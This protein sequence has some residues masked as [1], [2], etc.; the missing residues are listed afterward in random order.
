METDF[1]L[2]EHKSRLIVAG[3]A[4]DG[5]DVDSVPGRA[6]RSI[7]AAVWQSSG[8]KAAGRQL[9]LECPDWRWDGLANVGKRREE[10][11]SQGPNQWLIAGGGR[12]QNT[13]RKENRKKKK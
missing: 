10:R 2:F 7:A 4:D 11:D 1:S 5:V 6:R 9:K 12:E 13:N 8:S 3:I